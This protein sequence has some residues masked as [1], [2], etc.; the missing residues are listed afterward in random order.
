M[1]NSEK[2]DI[3]LESD[4]ALDNEELTEE[5]RCQEHYETALR[6]INIAKHM[7]QYEDQDK[8]YHRALKNL[9]LARAKVPGLKPMI[10]DVVDKKYYA[11]AQGK[12]ATYEEACKIR[13]LAR[14]ST[15]YYS[16]QTLFERIHKYEINHKIPEHLVTPEIYAQ[17][18]QCQDSEQQAAYCSE[19]ADKLLLQQRRKS[20]FSSLAIIAVIIAALAFSR[21]TLSRKCL[22]EAYSLTKNYDNAARWYKYVYQKSHDDRD[23]EN[24]KESQYKFA[25]KQSLISNSETVRGIF[26]ELA[27]LNYKDSEACLLRLE[28]ARIAEMPDG[29][30]IRFGNVNWRILTHEGS[31]VLLIKDKTVSALSFHHGGGEVT[32]DNSTIRR[33]LNQV[34]IDEL[35]PFESEKNALI[36][37]TLVPEDNTVYG[38]KD[39]KETTDKVFFLSIGEFS[40]YGSILPNTQNLWW[41]RTPGSTPETIAFVSTDKTIMAYGY[42]PGN[43]N[44]KTRPAV[45]VDVSE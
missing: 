43:T 3:Q 14:T 27:F 34:Y 6:Y 40:R 12:I 39:G 32:W 11:R 21:T 24:Y 23:F 38:T 41:L 8:Y 4:S 45:W 35:F 36:N 31:K 7:K 30:K 13:D 37:T 18:C 15:D 2:I 25:E 10:Q 22:A 19:M 1:K 42:D 29:E 16:A 33:W 44:I 17:V 26:R 9:R 28:K 20:Q 5:Q